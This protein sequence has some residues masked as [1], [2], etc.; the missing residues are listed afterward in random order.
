MFAAARDAFGPV[1]VL[2]NNAGVYTFAPLDGITQ[3]EFHR[4]FDVNVLGPFLTMQEFAKQPEADGGAIINISAVG[5][6]ATRPATALYTAT[7]AALTAATRVVAKE[8][9]PRRIRVNAIAP[10]GTDTEGTRALGVV[11]SAA[12]AELVAQIPLG[13]LG[14]PEDIGPVA[15]FLASED[16]RWITGEVIF[17]SSGHC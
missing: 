8:L 5:L 7:K 3:A 1:D 11:G 15:V 6:S 12:E 10:T 16:A 13:R 4:Q 17:A 2:V 14:L 9:A